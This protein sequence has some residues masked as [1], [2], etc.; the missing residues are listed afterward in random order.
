[1]YKGEFFGEAALFIDS[2]RGATVVADTEV[3]YNHL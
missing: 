1:M 3:C 2:K